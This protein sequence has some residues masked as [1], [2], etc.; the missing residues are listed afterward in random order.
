MSQIRVPPEVEVSPQ[1]GYPLNFDTETRKF[2]DWNNNEWSVE[3]L[4]ACRPGNRIKKWVL[5]NF[6]SDVRK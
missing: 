6:P 3:E 4:A 1:D 2:S 5:E